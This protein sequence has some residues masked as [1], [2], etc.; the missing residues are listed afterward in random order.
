MYLRNEDYHE[1]NRISVD[2]RVHDNP[3]QFAEEYQVAELLRKSLNIPGVDEADRQRAALTK[4][5]G[6]EARN[7]E[8][9]ARLMGEELP[10]WFGRFSSELLKVLGPL[11]ADELN[12][13]AE[14]GQFGP[15]V[16]VGVRGDGLVPSIKYDTKPVATKALAPLLSGLMPVHV[17]DF[18]GENLQEKTVVVRGNSHF[19]VPKNWEINRCAAKEPLWNSYLQSG[20]GSKMVKRLKRFGVDLHDQRLNQ[21]LASMAWEW[22][23]ATLDLSSASDLMARVLVWLALCY[24][25]D[26]DGKRWYHLL[27]LSRSPTMKIGDE[28]VALEMFSSMGNG[29]TFPLETMIFL[30]VLRCTV[31]REDW[32]LMTAYGDDMIMPQRSV[33]QVVERLE[34]LGFQVNRKKTCLAGSFFESCGT[35][36]FQSQNVRPFYLHK[37]PDNPAPYPLQ[38]ANA[39]RAWCKRVFGRLPRKFKSLWRWCRDQ[40]PRVWNKPIT[41]SL[42]DVGIHVGLSE[43]VRSRDVHECPPPGGDEDFA[44]WEGHIVKFVRVSP[45]NKDRKSFGVLC[46]GLRQ[47]ATDWW[48]PAKCSS[49]GL[50]AVRGLYGRVRTEIGVVLWEDDL[51]WG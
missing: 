6:A 17:S 7:A 30:A 9:N 3:E 49:K 23:L 4:F 42:G 40:V 39:L 16:N 25:G 26:P 33:E 44:G 45:V 12:E 22:D 38:A 36:W 32:C 48:D 50:E 51:N 10:P 37:S 27:N 15:G 41:P 46:C 5:L 43:A 24:N 8:T 13:I 18:W 28:E 19:T 20:I 21:A 11:G 1:L 14:L 2:P 31:P 47:R 35:D 34:Y 29:F